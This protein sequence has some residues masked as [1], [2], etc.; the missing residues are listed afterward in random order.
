MI[1]YSYNSAILLGGWELESMSD[2]VQLTNRFAG[3]YIK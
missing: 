3:D 2:F 1:L